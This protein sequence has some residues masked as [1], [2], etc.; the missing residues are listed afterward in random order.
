MFNIIIQLKN[1]CCF[2]M[3]ILSIHSYYCCLCRSC[4]QLSQKNDITSWNTFFKEIL[5]FVLHSNLHEPAE[6]DFY[7]KI[8]YIYN[9]LAKNNHLFPLFWIII[10]HHKLLLL[11]KLMYFRNP[12]RNS[13]MSQTSCFSF[14]KMHL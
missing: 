3:F 10:K 11:S 12:L 13:N 6:K 8:K 9:C 14:A 1:S 2:T 4:E 5:R 7:L